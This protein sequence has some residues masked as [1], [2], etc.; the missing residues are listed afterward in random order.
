MDHLLS[1]ESVIAEKGSFWGALNHAAMVHRLQAPLWILCSLS[2]C[3]TIYSDPCFALF[4]LFLD[5][6]LLKD[7]H[8]LCHS[9][10]VSAVCLQV[11]ANLRGRVLRFRG[12]GGI[13]AAMPSEGG[14]WEGRGFCLFGQMH[15][16]IS[17]LLS[18]IKGADDVEQIHGPCLISPCSGPHPS[19]WAFVCLILMTAP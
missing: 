1:A 16:P 9:I 10:F 13:V 12:V 19:L 11:R 7:A 15:R 5:S 2:F 6:V 4:L 3:L 18:V 17:E 8:P 14:V